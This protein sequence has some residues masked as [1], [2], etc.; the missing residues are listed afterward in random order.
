MRR[1][2]VFN[3][4]TVD[5]YIA[6]SVGD[7]SWAHKA[8]EDA[9]W[10]EFMDSNATGGGMLLFGRV[11]YEL[12]KNF[13]P[14]AQAAEMFP[15]VAERMNNLPKVAFSRTMDEA[16][17]TNTTLVKGDMVAA[18]RRMKDE[19][20]GGMAI[21]GSASIVAQLAEAGVI[22]EYQMAVSPVALGAGK[23]MFEGMKRKLALRLTKTRTFGNGVVFVCYEPA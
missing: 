5:G 4:V 18:V 6:D 13:W 20:G 10:R 2:V 16:T 12:M 7:M 3:A 9:E 23:T 1:L 15:V 8:R 17:W 21:L 14:T 19:E 22:D 11:T